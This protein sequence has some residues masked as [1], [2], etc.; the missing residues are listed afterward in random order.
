[1]KE[2][3]EWGIAKAY[4]DGMPLSDIVDKFGIGRCSVYY[5]LKKCGIEPNRKK[6]FA[7][8]REEYI[9]LY[10][11][12]VKLKEINA[13]YKKN[14]DVVIYRHTNSNRIRH[15]NDV[16]Q[17]FIK[18]NINKIKQE[19]I[20]KELGVTPATITYYKNKIK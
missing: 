17:E 8:M 11:E 19:D 1:M 5:Y 6:E 2:V 14:A 4:I 18:N 16:Q 20:A 10:N 12:G 13:K 15:L 7:K 9:K 3:I